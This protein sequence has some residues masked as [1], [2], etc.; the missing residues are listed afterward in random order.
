MDIY[1]FMSPD[2]HSIHATYP[3]QTRPGKP[4]R[5]S[6]ICRDRANCLLWPSTA[7]RLHSATTDDP[8]Y[9]HGVSRLYDAQMTPNWKY[10][11]PVGK[12]TRRQRRAHLR[13]YIGG[14]T[15]YI[16]RNMRSEGQR[17]PHPQH[18]PAVTYGESAG[19]IGMY[20]TQVPDM[21]P[22]PLSP[23]AKRKLMP[24]KPFF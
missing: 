22:T 18:P 24:R 15:H 14:R 2:M 23:D 6:C 9:S 4:C 19:Y 13:I 10:V 5:T 21:A 1:I 7:R 3:A 17:T 8:T 11:E 12:S 16:V 20:S